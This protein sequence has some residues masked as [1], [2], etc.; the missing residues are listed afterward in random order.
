MW[1]GL[2]G[3]ETT[4]GRRLVLNIQGCP[5]NA[6]PKPKSGPAREVQKHH[7]NIFT[8]SPC[9]KLFQNKSTKISMS[10]FPRLFLFYRVF[11]CFLAMGVQKYYKKR[12]AKNRVEMFLQTLSGCPRTGTR[13]PPRPGRRQIIPFRPQDALNNSEGPPKKNRGPPWWVGGSEA[14]KGLGSDFV[15]SPHRET[16][17]NMIKRKPR[18]NRIWIFGRFVCKHFS[19]RC[20]WYNVFVRF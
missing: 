8:T 17:K 3:A 2:G 10:V 7:A 15:D 13:H 19:T 16:P 4:R 12:F 14:K 6:S 18:K 1:G 11:G 9:R 20:F 5:G